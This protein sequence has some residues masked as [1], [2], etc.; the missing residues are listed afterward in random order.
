MKLTA[1]QL[2]N[3]IK[4]E[5]MT[6]RASPSTIEEISKVETMIANTMT[7]INASLESLRSL[8]EKE[9]DDRYTGVG[10]AIETIKNDFAN[11]IKEI[12]RGVGGYS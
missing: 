3:L 9:Y 6:E 10:K 5:L 1:S 4:E 8:P 2:K 7:N 12:N 11:L